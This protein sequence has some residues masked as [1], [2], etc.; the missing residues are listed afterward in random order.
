MRAPAH[1]RVE[2]MAGDEE[3]GTGGRPFR[4]LVADDMAANFELLEGVLAM[5]G[6]T[7]EWAAS[8]AVAL[9]MLR[10][11]NYDLLLLDLHMPDM[12]GTEVIRRLRSDPGA[13]IPKI[14]VAT[15][16]TWMASS[17]EMLMVGADGVFTKPLDIR[18][19]TAFVD[20]LLPAGDAAD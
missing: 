20:T 18:A 3:S 17:A 14:V 19:L 16:D 12:D 10:S 5:R 13:H 6:L 8:G 7:P 4:I 11:A 9:N 15:A 1:E 2:V